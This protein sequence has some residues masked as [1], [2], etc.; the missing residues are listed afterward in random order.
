MSDIKTDLCALR[1]ILSNANFQN[2][3]F[4]I[5]KSKATIFCYPVVKV[6][7]TVLCVNKKLRRP[8]RNLTNFVF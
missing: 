6:A 3:T 5:S 1:A 8:G 4:S 7:L 2:K